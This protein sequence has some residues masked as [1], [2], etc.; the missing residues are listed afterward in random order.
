MGTVLYFYSS[1]V[2][3]ALDYDPFIKHASNGQVQFGNPNN[4]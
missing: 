4:N 1:L 2:W 3:R